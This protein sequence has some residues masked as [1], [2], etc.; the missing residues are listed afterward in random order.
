MALKVFG[1]HLKLIEQKGE[2]V[3]TVMS[4]IPGV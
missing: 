1:D 3:V 2:E 4:A